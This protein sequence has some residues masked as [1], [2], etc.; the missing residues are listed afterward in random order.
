[1]IDD[2]QHIVG[3][4]KQLRK[5]AFCFVFFLRIL[6]K[7]AVFELTNMGIVINKGLIEIYLLK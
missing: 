3:D 7:M 1:M 5:H 4:A 6:Y 2:S